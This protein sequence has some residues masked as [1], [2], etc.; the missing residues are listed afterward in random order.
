MIIG[1]FR[2]NLPSTT[3]S[4][5]RKSFVLTPTRPYA[6]TP[7]PLSAQFEDEFDADNDDDFQGSSLGLAQTCGRGPG[8]L[9]SNGM[10]G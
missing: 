6:V 2:L 1:S 4:R 3:L 7:T 8:K 10:E 9:V 5:H